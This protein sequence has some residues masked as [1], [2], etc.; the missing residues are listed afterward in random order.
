MHKKRLRCP[1]LLPREPRLTWQCSWVWKKFGHSVQS[2][3]SFSHALRQKGIETVKKYTAG[4]AGSKKEVSDRFAPAR[5]PDRC[6]RRIPIGPAV[7]VNRLRRI[8]SGHQ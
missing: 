4:N 8:R 2:S 5:I 6:K 7:S 1:S 3:K